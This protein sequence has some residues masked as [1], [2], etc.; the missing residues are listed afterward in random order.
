MQNQR[1]RIAQAGGAG[2]DRHAV[3]HFFPRLNA[4]LHFEAYHRAEPL[5]LLLGKL[6][7]GVR[8]EAGIVDALDLLM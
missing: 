1:P 3:H 5:H 8:G 4:A 2:E 6:M 7:T